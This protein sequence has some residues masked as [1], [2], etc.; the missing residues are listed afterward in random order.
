MVFFEQKRALKYESLVELETSLRAEAPGWFIERRANNSA[1][2]TIVLSNVT[3]SEIASGLMRL[4]SCG[5]DRQ[6]IE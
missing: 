3:L 1:E 6:L 4:R 5:Q 2:V